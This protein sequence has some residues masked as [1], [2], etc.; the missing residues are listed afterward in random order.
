MRMDSNNNNNNN[1]ADGVCSSIAEDDDD[2]DDDDDE[3]PTHYL[4][5]LGREKQS[6]RS[7]IPEAGN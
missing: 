6:I 7:F 3:C 1:M 5:G 2:D 4:F